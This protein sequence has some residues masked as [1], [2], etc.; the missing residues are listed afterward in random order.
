MSTVTALTFPAQSLE[1]DWRSW[2]RIGQ[3]E[4]LC[5]GF[6]RHDGLCYRHEVGKDVRDGELIELRE[7]VL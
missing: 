6:G 2:R 4:R 1:R 3:E 7:A 5:R